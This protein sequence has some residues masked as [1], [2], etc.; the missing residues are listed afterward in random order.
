MA[1]DKRRAVSDKASQQHWC[2]PGSVALACK[3][4]RQERP[5]QKVVAKGG[6]NGKEQCSGLEKTG[7]QRERRGRWV[8]VLTE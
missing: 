5:E 4:T 3:G 7:T 8:V 2:A 6:D 1:M